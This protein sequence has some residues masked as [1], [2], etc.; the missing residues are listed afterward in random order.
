MTPRHRS[1]RTSA[2]FIEY[3]S[4]NQRLLAVNAPTIILPVVFTTTVLVYDS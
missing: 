2:G 1:F 4:K 3:V